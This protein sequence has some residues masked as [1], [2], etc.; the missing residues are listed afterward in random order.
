MD[1]EVGRKLRTPWM[2]P[3]RV[4]DKLT[5]IAYLLRS[6]SDHRLARV[7][8]NR[9]RAF[10]ENLKETND[11]LDGVFPDSRRLIRNISADKKVRGKKFFKIKRAYSRREEWVPEDDLP[12]LVIEE[13][14][15]MK[16]NRQS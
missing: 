15:A 2:G 13:Y 1:M 3:Y 16:A 9:L 6:E 12:D 5:S 7:H 4:E 10:D 14:F 8:V 11:A